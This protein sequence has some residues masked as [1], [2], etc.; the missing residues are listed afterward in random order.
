MILGYNTNGMAHHEFGDALRLLAEIGYRSVAITVDV[1]VL[2]PF[3]PDIERQ[4]QRARDL[5][6]S[7]E[8]SSVIETGARFLLDPGRKHEPTLVSGDP[9]HRARRIAFYKYA[10]DCAAELGSQCVSLWSGTL[11]DAI[12]YEEGM[13]RLA[14]GLDEVLAYAT[15]QGVMIGFEP[16]PGM[17]IDSTVRYDELVTLLDNP[18]LGLTLDIGHLHCQGETPIAD[19]I[20]RWAHQLVNVH[21]EDMSKG[22]HEHLFFGE[23]EID[24]PA[25]IQ[26][27]GDAEY[28]G[29]VHVELSR[30]SHL[31]P[32]A[33]RGA[34]D[35]LNPLLERYQ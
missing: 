5:L 25:V 33:A 7:L 29:G 21:L 4:I 28:Q 10:I 31:A 27:L 16:E 13:A 22:V 12:S 6:E 1:G 17:L 23:G 30:H 18:S 11:H 2:P 15:G 14:A 32:T 26:A 8:L 9:A 20:H 35:F 3:A 19:H 34:F 24:F